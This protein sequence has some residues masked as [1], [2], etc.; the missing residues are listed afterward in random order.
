MGEKGNT[1]KCS[2]NSVTVATDA[3][4]FPLR[5]W[6]SLGP[7]S[8]KKWCGTYSDKPDGKW[9]KTAERMMLQLHTESGNPIFRS[10]S[11]LV[12]GELRSK[13]HGKKKIRFN[14]GEENIELL[15]RTTISANQLSVYGAIV[16]L[17]IR[18]FYDFGETWST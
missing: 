10:S 11:A 1:E 15:L 7:G 4:R 3:R 5:R 9:D 16:D 6:S 13:G 8:E 14:G 2:M 17:C 12:R 18:R